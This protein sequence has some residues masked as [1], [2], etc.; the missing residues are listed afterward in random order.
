M[1]KVFL[2]IMMFSLI[3]AGTWNNL[4][5]PE[6]NTANASWLIPTTTWKAEYED[7]GLSYYMWTHEGT[8]FCSGKI[9]GEPGYYVK[10][11]RVTMEMIVVNIIIRQHILK[12]LQETQV[13][14][15]RQREEILLLV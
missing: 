7:Y 2:F 5:I 12:F 8:Y 15:L 11:V 10:T 14:I 6:Y 9:N 4:L 1:K 13:Q 3:L